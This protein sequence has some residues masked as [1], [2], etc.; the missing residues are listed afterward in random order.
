MTPKRRA[1]IAVGCAILL[2]FALGACTW[3]VPCYRLIPCCSTLA[4]RSTDAIRAELLDEVPIGSPAAEVERLLSRRGLDL[5]KGG[6]LMQ[7]D[8]LLPEP[9]NGS[10]I[11]AH[12]GTYYFVWR[13][14]VVAY[15]VLD[16]DQ[17]VK[18]V[19]VSRFLDAP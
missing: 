5:R 14:D 3:L 10:L 11:S 4:F 7:S 2:L 1:A 13:T 12:L 6:V 15:W 8:R 18:E 16:D 17:R 19:V 9:G